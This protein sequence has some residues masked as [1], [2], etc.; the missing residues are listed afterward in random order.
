MHIMG[1]ERVWLERWEGRSPTALPAA[2]EFPTLASVRTRW[3]EVEDRQRRFVA[4]LSADDLAGVREV[5]TLTMGTVATPLWQ[6][7]QHVMN[8]S[9]YHRG[10]VVTLLR[11]LGATPVST[12]LIRFYRERD[13]A[14]KSA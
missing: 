13:A 12:D 6:S 4:G 3:A 1:A 9:T 2:A 7:L 10:Q 14:A 11:Q 5:R 8:H